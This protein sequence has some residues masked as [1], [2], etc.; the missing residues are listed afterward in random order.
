MIKEYITELY[1]Y[2]PEDARIILCQFREDPQSES[3]SRW[4]PRVLRRDGD[5]I[6]EYSNVYVCISAMRQNGRG[7]WRR[8]NNCFAGGLMVMLDDVEKLPPDH[9]KP[10]VIVETSPNSF[11]YHYFLDRLE[12]NQQKFD[13]LIRGLVHSEIL[14]I[15]GAGTQSI[16]RVCRPPIGK[17][18]KAKYGD[19][20]PFVKLVEVDFSHR[21]SCEELAAGLGAKIL[22][23]SLLK[24]KDM[25]PL[26]F[27]DR[28]IMYY[29]AMK[30]LQWSGMIKV[31]KPDYSG[32][33]E[34]QCPFKD[35]LT[36]EDGTVIIEPHSDG[37]DNGAAIREPAPENHFYGA[38]RCHHNHAGRGKEMQQ[39]GWGDLTQW[40]NDQNV[41][42]LGAV[43]LVAPKNLE[44][45]M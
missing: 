10:T 17:N 45:L 31:T 23:R 44:E 43:N 1:K 38:F 36:S 6:D 40:L 37:A 42:V 12:T 22:N 27:E 41:G 33:I 19:P 3:T 20:S 34:M 11:Q 21:Y 30:Q 2:V 28:V 35:G 7:E 26:S 32:W 9:P 15:D 39:L 8:R 25:N 29:E 13:G 4:R 14:S 24:R 18:T 16:T 5:N